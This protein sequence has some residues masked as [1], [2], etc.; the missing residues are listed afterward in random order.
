M[1]F[2]LPK[3]TYDYNALEPFID[4]LTTEIHYSKHHAT[5]VSNLNKALEEFPE[6]QNRTIE[7]LLTSLDT[8]PEKLQGPVKNNG[9]GHYNHSLFWQFIAPNSLSAEPIDGLKTEINET[10]GDFAKK[11]R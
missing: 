1:K 4:A 2:E 6:L 10:F 9:G 11:Q 8:L 5:Y 7:E 3:L